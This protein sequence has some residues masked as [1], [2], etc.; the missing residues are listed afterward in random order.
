[1]GADLGLPEDEHP[2]LAQCISDILTNEHLLI[3]HA[4]R[5]QRVAQQYALQIVHRLS[6]L[7]YDSEQK[8][9]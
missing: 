3:P 1:M 8:K 4:I 2:Q 7:K 9:T 6:A 5:I